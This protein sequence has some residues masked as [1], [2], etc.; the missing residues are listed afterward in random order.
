MDYSDLFT[1]DGASLSEF[2]TKYER[3]ALLST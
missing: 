3:D 1:A 2:G